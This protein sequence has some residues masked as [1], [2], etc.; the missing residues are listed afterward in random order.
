[1]QKPIKNNQ[2]NSPN[3]PLSHT[4]FF[5]NNVRAGPKA[6]QYQQEQY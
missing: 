5:A 6:E 2:V 1:M 4:A 3:S